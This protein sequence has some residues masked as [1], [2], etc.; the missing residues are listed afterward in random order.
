PPA[1]ESYL[2]VEALLAAARTAGADAVHPGYGFLAEN[3]AFARAVVE[4]GVG[5]GG[6]PPRGAP[7]PGGN[8]AAPRAPGAARGSRRRGGGGRGRRWTAPTRPRPRAG[9]RAWGIRFW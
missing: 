5:L 4:A 7:T 1:R 3:A 9:P 2:S 8:G 6:A